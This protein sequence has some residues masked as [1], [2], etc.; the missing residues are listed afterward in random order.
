MKTRALGV[1]LVSV[2][3]LAAV[4]AFRWAERDGR[5]DLETVFVT[6]IGCCDTT[7]VAEVIQHAFGV[8]LHSIDTDSLAR[9]LCSVPGVSAASVTLI[10][11]S[12]AHLEITLENAA[13]VLE[14]PSGQVPVNRFCRRLP[15]A[16][17]SGDLPVIRYSADPDTS[18]LASAVKFTDWLGQQ[19]ENTV[20]ILDSTGVNVMENDLLILLGSE[21]LEER[22][23]SWG[24]V[25][26][27]ATG[28]CQ[29]D[30]RFRGQAVFRRN[31]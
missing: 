29:V 4:L 30:L 18:L 19:R 26:P 27:L 14:T 9:E 3:L 6:G 31:S 2:L 5:F 20:V 28:A 17:M 24:L 15:D 7:A 23:I 25:S 16:W 12:S 8:A 10:W 13:A 1:S 21:R 22:W 11:P